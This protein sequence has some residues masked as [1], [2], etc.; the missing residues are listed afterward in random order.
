MRRSPQNVSVVQ[1]E[2]ECSKNEKSKFSLKSPKLKLFMCKKSQ[3]EEAPRPIWSQKSPKL[4]LDM[5]VK[6]QV[7]EIARPNL[8]K[9][10]ESQVQIKF[11]IEK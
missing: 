2:V 3:I 5:C 1:I 11:L 8:S 9:C 7:D 4:K 6:S 10:T